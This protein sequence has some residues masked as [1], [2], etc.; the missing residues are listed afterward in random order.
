VLE[1][2]FGAHGAL[3]TAGILCLTFGTLTLVAAPIPQMDVSPLVAI[4]VSL[5]FGLIT[6][7]L[8][9]LVIR[10]QRR[11]ARIGADAM[12]GSRATAMEAL[13]P[14]GHVLVE[15]EIWQ[16]VAA[17]PVAAGA[18]LRVVG[19]DQMILQVEPAQ[20]PESTESPE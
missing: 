14:E 3:A 8:L 2:K 16:A 7:F 9:R 1:A 15:G 17:Q 11:K 18:D 13:A 19:V 10:A 12:V 4:A 20:P 5:G 6:V